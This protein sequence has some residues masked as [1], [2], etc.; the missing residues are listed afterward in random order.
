VPGG[1][2]EVDETNSCEDDLSAGWYGELAD[3]SLEVRDGRG[4]RL[5][6]GDVNLNV[7]VTG[8]GD[9]GTFRHDREVLA[10]DGVPGA[11][12]ADEDMLVWGGRLPLS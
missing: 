2:P 8:V 6:L 11:D 12:S 3:P 7:E 5:R 1:T 4:V 9:D 10:S